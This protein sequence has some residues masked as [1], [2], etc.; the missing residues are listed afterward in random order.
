[1]TRITVNVIYGEGGAEARI[2]RFSRDLTGR[3]ST[4]SV[5]SGESS[6]KSIQQ[7]GRVHSRGLLEV[8]VAR[9]LGSCYCKAEETTGMT[10]S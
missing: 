4:I 7:C 3:P 5:G 6:F 10:Q 9:P 2:Q 1:M 8:T